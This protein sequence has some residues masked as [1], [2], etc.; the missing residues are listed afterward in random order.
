MFFGMP[1]K[2]GGGPKGQNTS[3]PSSSAPAAGHRDETAWHSRILLLSLGDQLG[4]D[5]RRL[6]MKNPIRIGRISCG[7]DPNNCG[8]IVDK[9]SA[10]PTSFPCARWAY[11]EWVGS[12]ILQ[13]SNANQ[14]REDYHEV[15]MLGFITFAVTS[16]NEEIKNAA[17]NYYIKAENQNRRYI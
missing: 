12:N 2:H 14:P 17:E 11:D 1:A 7:L 10:W 8:R 13:F 5:T 4:Q 9:S 16:G 6:W 15:L 3:S